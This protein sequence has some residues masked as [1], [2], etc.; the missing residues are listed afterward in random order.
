[1]GSGYPCLDECAYHKEQ[2]AGG[3]MMCQCYIGGLANRQM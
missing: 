2:V 3:Y 1:M